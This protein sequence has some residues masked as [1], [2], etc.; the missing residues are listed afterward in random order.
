[1]MVQAGVLYST[2]TPRQAEAALGWGE[3]SS[4]AALPAL[5]I[6]SGREISDMCC[7]WGSLSAISGGSTAA[8][9]GRGPSK[10][11]RSCRAALKLELCQTKDLHKLR[12]P[13]ASHSRVGGP[14]RKLPSRLTPFAAHAQPK[15]PCPGLCLCLPP[16]T[17]NPG[18]PGRLVASSS[19]SSLGLLSA[20]L[21][22]QWQLCHKTLPTPP[23]ELQ[24]TDW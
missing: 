10:T 23:P 21:G 5:R 22:H 7:M 11:G 3:D 20:S 16:T 15:G 17:G 18:R 19:G 12:S 4:G 9:N 8:R 2:W 13:P 24:V 6:E 1:M 14:R